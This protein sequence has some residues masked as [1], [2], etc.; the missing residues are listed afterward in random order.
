MSDGVT[1]GEWEVQPHGDGF[2]IVG[3]DRHRRNPIAVGIGNRADARLMAASKRMLAELVRIRRL[4]GGVPP[5]TLFSAGAI[6]NGGSLADAADDATG[7]TSADPPL[8]L[9]EAQSLA[10]AVLSGDDVAALALADEVRERLAEPEG[11]VPR[12]ELLRRI[13]ELETTCREQSE[14]LHRMNDPQDD[15]RAACRL[16]DRVGPLSDAGFCARC[17]DRDDVTGEYGEDDDHPYTEE[18]AAPRRT[19]RVQTIGSRSIEILYEVADGVGEIRSGQELGLDADGRLTPHAPPLVRAMD[20]TDANG[21]PYG[22][23]DLSRLF[24]PPLPPERPE[25]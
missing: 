14:E 11:F 2:R 25:E 6:Y 16:C 23:A 24:G 5:H 8:P 10:F 21:D 7:R 4:V 18:P 1:I 19:A 12:A 17:D 15:G 9:T 22:G 3:P 13:A 20:T